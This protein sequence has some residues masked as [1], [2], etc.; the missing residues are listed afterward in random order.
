MGKKKI[1]L[2]FVISPLA[3]PLVFLVAIA[4]RVGVGP[5]PAYIP[6]SFLIY[7]PFAYIAMALLGLPAFFLYC[8]KGWSNPV[9]YVLGGMAIGLLCAWVILGYGV[10]WQVDSVD[11]LWCVMAGGVSAIVFWLI[12]YKLE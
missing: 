2:A 6:F 10:S 4:C 11:Y 5:S 7:T 1:V 8:S 3:T 12:I 9:L